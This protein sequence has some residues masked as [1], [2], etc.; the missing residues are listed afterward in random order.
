MPLSP[1]GKWGKWAGLEVCS[2]VSL[3]ADRVVAG[4]SI[5]GNSLFQTLHFL[6]FSSWLSRRSRT[7]AG[8]ESM[9]PKT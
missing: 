3:A 7:E 4:L 6:P 8:F 5:D 9:P 1:F 2:V